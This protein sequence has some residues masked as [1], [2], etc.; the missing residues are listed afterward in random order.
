MLSN[1][2]LTEWL[3]FRGAQTDKSLLFRFASYLLINCTSLLITGPLLLLLVSALGI[4]ALLAN[5]LSLLLL[6]LGRFAIA[7]SY[8]W[9]N[10]SLGPRRLALSRTQSA[11]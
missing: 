11:H 5:V 8:I 3:V 2:V 1:F 4:D 6:V 10:K 7:D 9:G